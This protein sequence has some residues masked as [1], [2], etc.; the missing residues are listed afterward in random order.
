MICLCADVDRNLCLKTA[1]MAWVVL[2]RPILIV[3]GLVVVTTTRTVVVTSGKCLTLGNDNFS[4]GFA[5]LVFGSILEKAP[6]PSY[7]STL[8]V[9]LVC[10]RIAWSQFFKRNNSTT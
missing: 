10:V 7:A 5:I 9:V 6:L 2:S 4:E 1:L 3:D 8:L